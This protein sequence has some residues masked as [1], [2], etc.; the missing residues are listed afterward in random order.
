MQGARNRNSDKEKFLSDLNCLESC[1]M[2]ERPLKT[3][4]N[5][6]DFQAEYEGSIPFTLSKCGGRSRAEQQNEATPQDTFKY[7]CC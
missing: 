5:S 2:S 3:L 7:R 4:R 6:E 1:E